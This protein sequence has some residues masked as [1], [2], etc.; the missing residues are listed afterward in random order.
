MTATNTIHGAATSIGGKYN[1]SPPGTDQLVHAF[2]L[3]RDLELDAAKFFMGSAYSAEWYT[4]STWTGSPVSLKQLAQESQ[5]A[6]I[7]GDATI[8]DY[9]LNCFTFTGG[10]IGDLWKF[11][12]GPF[13]VQDLF[14][15]EYD[16]LK[17]FAEYL[18]TTYAGTDKRFIL[19]S[20]EGDWALISS[21]NINDTP[22][23][24]RLRVDRMVAWLQARQRAVEDA[25][26]NIGQYRVQVLHAV[27][28]NRV[29]DCIS[30]PAI[31]RVATSVLPRIRCDLVSYSAYDSV[32][33]L[34][35]GAV[36]PWYSSYNE[37]AQKLPERMTTAVQFLRDVSDTEV[38]IGEWGIPEN[39]MPTVGGYNIATMVTDVFNTLENLNVPWSIWWQCID[40]ELQPGATVPYSNNE[41]KGYW[42]YDTTGA[43]TTAGIT[44]GSL[45]T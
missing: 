35:P 16:E 8:K 43:K 31:R 37:W 24:N 21:T 36:S 27:E 23:I 22:L 34:Q 39:D 7:F 25:R 3:V 28:V 14:T 45:V 4:F 12:E 29:Q 19:Q 5:F 44:F 30:E 11:G 1:I 13:A 17:E 26:K 20:W 38:F 40:N 33:N 42:L 9:L 15:K 10:G 6:T 2:Q 32:F 18:L 41:L